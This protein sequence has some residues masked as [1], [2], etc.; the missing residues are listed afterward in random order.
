MF[1]VLNSPEEILSKF[2]II[3]YYFLLLLSIIV[4]SVLWEYA[5][6]VRYQP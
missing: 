1:L 4:E 5:R 3:D 6:V 2:G